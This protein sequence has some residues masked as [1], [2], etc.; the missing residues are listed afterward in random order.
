M[1]IFLSVMS[2][3]IPFTM[4]LIGVYWKHHA[5]KRVNWIYGYRSTMSMKNEETWE[6][7]HKYHAEVWLW[8]GAIL[9]I[10]SLIPLAV[11]I[12]LNRE[13]MF[14]QYIGII[15]IIQ[16]AVLVLSII[17]TERALRKH[18]DADGNPKL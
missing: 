10:L 14:E 6:F 16:C 8:S 4:I 5:P 3:L 17:P 13:S 15:M 2:M 7:A 1:H 11:L 9:A 12:V 18:F